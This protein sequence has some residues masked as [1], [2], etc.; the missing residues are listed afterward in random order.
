MYYRDGYYFH[1]P[2]ALENVMNNKRNKCFSNLEVASA[3]FL[4]IFVRSWTA[5]GQM[6]TSYQLFSTWQ[7]CCTSQTSVCYKCCYCTLWLYNFAKPS[8]IIMF[9]PWSIFC[10]FCTKILKSNNLLWN[11]WYLVTQFSSASDF[12][13]SVIFEMWT[14]HFFCWKRLCSTIAHY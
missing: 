12:S 5:P 1:T 2:D 8:N 6:P 4:A 14:L 11:Q 13:W 7:T 3:T 10:E 9:A